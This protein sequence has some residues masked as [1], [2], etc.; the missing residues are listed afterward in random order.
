MRYFMASGIF[1]AR[2]NVG[3][4]VIMKNIFAFGGF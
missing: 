4:Y 1:S 2:E 3:N